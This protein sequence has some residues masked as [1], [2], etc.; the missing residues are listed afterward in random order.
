MNTFFPKH[1]IQ[2]AIK[3]AESKSP[4]ESCGFFIKNN[5]YE[6]IPCE[7]QAENKEA[8]FKISGKDFIETSIKGEIKCILHSH[9][10]CEW[11]SES[12]QKEQQK[13]KIPFGVIFLKNNCYS[14]IIFFGD[15]LPVQSLLSRPFIHGAYDCYGLVRDFYRKELQ[16]QLYNYPRE[17]EWWNTDNNLLEGNMINEGFT[18]VNL[19]NIKMHDVILFKIRGKNP[20]HSAVYLGRDLILHHMFGKLSGR[21]PIGPYRRFIVSVWRHNKI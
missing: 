19:K 2:E 17:M 6:F 4:E 14:D 20:N 16:I 8:N 3:Y 11:V 15:E 21:E 10:N 1:I 12:D 7:N 5:D 13:H 18:R 9:N